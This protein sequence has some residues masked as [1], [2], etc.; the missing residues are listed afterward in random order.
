MNTSSPL[1][2]L[3]TYARPYKA[4]LGWAVLAMAVYAVGSAGLAALIKTI[5]DQVLQD[6][7]QLGTV[8]TLVIILNLLKG[9]GS[10][11]SAYLMAWVGQR[12]VMDVRK[13]EDVR[14]GVRRLRLHCPSH[15]ATRSG[16]SAWL[17]A[18]IPL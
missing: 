1:A 8:A 13:Q 4:R 6:S 14:T 9:L 12:V 11:A 15:R 10:Y 17:N 2:R 7:S 5:F 16:R 3:F 18:R